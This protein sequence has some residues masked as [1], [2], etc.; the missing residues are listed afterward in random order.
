MSTWTP[1]INSFQIWYTLLYGHTFFLAYTSLW[2]PFVQWLSFS[3]PHI[4]LHITAHVRSYCCP[5]ELAFQLLRNLL[6]FTSS[7]LVWFCG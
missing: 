7:T 5:I 1:S 6:V 3:G 4:L 2:H